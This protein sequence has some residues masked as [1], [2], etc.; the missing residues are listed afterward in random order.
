MKEIFYAGISFGFNSSACVIS[1]TRGIVAAISQER[2]N[3]EKNTKEVPLD[4]L[5]ACCKIANVKTLEGIAF[6]HYQELKFEELIKYTNVKYKNIISK[7]KTV[8][9]FFKLILLDNDILM[10]NKKMLR[11]NHH[12]AHMY[13]GVGIY[14]VN[15]QFVSITSDGFGDGISAKIFVKNGEESEILSE[16]RLENSVALVYQFVTGALGY[17]MHQHEGKITGLAAFG[18]PIYL[19]DF[20]NLYFKT[21]TGNGI[22]LRVNDAHLLTLEEEEMIAN[23]TIED[24]DKFLML[25]QM[26]F[27][28]VEDLKEDGAEDSDIAASLQKFT[29]EV[30]INWINEKLVPWL[31]ENDLKN[32]V[33]CYLAGGLFANVKLN[34]RIKDMNLFKDVL[35]SPPMGDEGTALGSAI[36][37]ALK[38]GN[39]SFDSYKNT[40]LQRVTVGTEILK[41]CDDLEIETFVEQNK[42][43]VTMSRSDCM[44]DLID[45]VATKLKNKKIVCLCKGAIEFGPRALCNRSILYDCTD[46]T[47]NDWLNKQI[48]RT[49]FMPFA[50]VCLEKDADSLFYNLDGGRQSAKFMTM[51][52][53][54]KDEFINDYPAACHVDNTARPQLVTADTDF[55]MNSILEEYKKI[56]NKKVLINT[57]FNLHNRPI[58]ESTED[59]LESWLTSNTDTLV[60]EG[61]IIERIDERAN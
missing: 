19:E 60:I 56:S 29:E 38:D 49:E 52:F 30:N 53:D 36:F 24:F 43:K 41:E 45:K 5:I 6:S 4:A 39:Y 23:S 50:P 13:S 8:D 2:L 51:T 7:A 12:T 9:D 34:Q 37:L 26:V 3:G 58:I 14:G 22:S 27:E 15:E 40:P 10:N 20:E 57:S 48:G 54:C 55:L 21:K 32:K 25:K 28:L 46:K 18:S 47:V 11:I 16:V 17:K 44:T 33:C 31:E 1:N 35:V 61:I 42:D 59:A